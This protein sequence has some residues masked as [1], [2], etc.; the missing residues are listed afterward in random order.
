VARIPYLSDDEATPDQLAVLNAR[1][2][3]FGNN[4]AFQRIVTRTPNVARWFLPFGYAL[5]RGDAG[6]LLDGRTKELAVLKTSMINAC[7]FCTAHNKSLGGAVGLT[8]QEIDELEGDYEQSTVLSERDKAIVHWAESVTKNEARRDMV[9][10]ERLK[11]F[12]SDDEIVEL[13]WVSAL[14]NMINRVTDALWLDVEEADLEGIRK[15]VTEAGILEYVRRI[16]AHAEATAA[17]AEAH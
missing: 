4:T 10:F 15:P 3:V 14:F 11:T 6:G 1:R 12:F 8:E 5:Q 16:L 17:P 13:T 2:E 7:G 9:G